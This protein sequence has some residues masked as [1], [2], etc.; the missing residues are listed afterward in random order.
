MFV[1]MVL[2]GYINSLHQT[3]TGSNTVYEV[4]HVLAIR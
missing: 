1:I 3:A 4:N 2:W